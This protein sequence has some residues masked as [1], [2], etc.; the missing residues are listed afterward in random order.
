MLGAV[1]VVGSGGGG[2]STS[3]QPIDTSTFSPIDA[4]NGVSVAASTWGMLSGAF[5]LSLPI[6]QWDLANFTCDN[7][8]T[9]SVQATGSGSVV[10]LQFTDCVVAS[11]G[12]TLNGAVT[13]DLLP[14]TPSPFDR[15]A[16]TWKI[17]AD[18]TFNQFTVDDGTTTVTVNGSASG[19][20]A[21]N[22]AGVTVVTT[23]TGNSLSLQVGSQSGTLLNFTLTRTDDQGNGTYTLA[24][25]GRLDDITL[26]GLFGFNTTTTLTGLTGSLPFS[27]NLQISGSNSSSATLIVLDG[28]N[29]RIQVVDGAGATTNFDTTWA[30][31]TGP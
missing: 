17:A 23:L 29:V 21:S 22:N 10:S 11:E 8:P 31:I 30:A 16:A 12:V 24:A 25:T 13:L 1:L 2:S 4:N 5:G 28:T 27:G 19:T 7:D 3:S 26:G 6:L 15:T 9:G 20:A 18:L 14:S